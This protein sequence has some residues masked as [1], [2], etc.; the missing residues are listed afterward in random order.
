MACTNCGDK[1][2]SQEI[3]KVC[4]LVDGDVRVKATQ[5]CDVCEAY[6]CQGC[7]FDLV[8]RTQAFMRKITS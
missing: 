1:F 8:R 7:K 3:C 2:S 5:W 4:E 6:I